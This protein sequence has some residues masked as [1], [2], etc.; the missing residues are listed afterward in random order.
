[1]GQRITWTRNTGLGRSGWDGT[2]NG[3]KLFTIEMSV[4]RG[5]GWILRTRL[6]VRLAPEQSSGPDSGAVMEFAE[7]VLVHFVRLLGAD[8]K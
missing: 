6:P 8:F 5:E 3:R 4:V 2:V 1:M 7:R